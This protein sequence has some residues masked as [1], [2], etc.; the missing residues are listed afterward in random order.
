MWSFA[1]G[2]APS[3]PIAEDEIDPLEAFMAEI[4]ALT[5]EQDAAVAKPGGD[6]AGDTGGPGAKVLRPR[7]TSQALL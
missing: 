5:A 4:N 7:P 6:G 1:Q 2:L 3:A